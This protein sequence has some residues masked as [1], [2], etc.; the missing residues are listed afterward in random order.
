MHHLPG[1]RRVR[2][3]RKNVID[4]FAHLARERGYAEFTVGEVLERANVG[5]STFYAH[6][7]GK[8]D[9]LLQALGMFHEL[10]ADQVLEALEGRGDEGRL[11]GLL[12]HFA[13]NRVLFRRLSIGPAAQAYARSARAFAARLEERL[14]R[15]G[16]ARGLRFAVPL[17]NVAS[18]LASALMAA[19][20]EWLDERTPSA[21]AEAQ[22]RALRRLAVASAQSAWE[23]S[24]G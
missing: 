3:T 4:A 21:P 13:E 9:V 5:R 15:H 6:Y 24:S 20:A 2:R 22:A 12:A 1:D 17:A 14:A 23:S 8:D 16:E 18:G 10:L 7:R 19:I 11:A